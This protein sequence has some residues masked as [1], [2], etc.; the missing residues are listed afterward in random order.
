M[1]YDNIADIRQQ[2][3]TCWAHYQQ[4]KPL[5]PLEQQ[6]VSVIIAHPEFQAN[7]EDRQALQ[8]QYFPELGE[9]NPFL[10]M[11]LHLAIREQVQ[12]NRPAGIQAI[13]H[14]L[15]T[16]LSPL[17]AEHALMN[18]LAECLWQA[19]RQQTPPD[20]AAFLHACTQL[21]TLEKD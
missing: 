1:F 6:L 10:H 8:R 13:Y 4:Q 3:I 21:A 2:F 14:Q 16:R 11:G 18:C 7:L 12:T 17:D 19:Q 5:T 9:T 15:S 20:E